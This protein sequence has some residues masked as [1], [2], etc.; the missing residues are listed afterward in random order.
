MSA[1]PKL[2]V[3]E[4]WGVGDQAM[5]T[6]FLQEASRRYRVWLLGKPYAA[7]LRPRFWPQV[8][9]IPWT[10][11][12]TV[13]RGKYRLHR[14]PWGEIARV[15]MRLRRERFDFGVSG[16]WDPRD[17]FLMFLAGVRHRIGFRRAGSQL[18]LTRALE[19]PDPRAHRYD[20][21]R[22]AGRPLEIDLPERSQRKAPPATGRALGVV[23]TG[24]AQPVRVWPLERYRA[25]VDRLRQRGWT[26]QV[27]C[28]SGQLNEW[29]QQ[30]EPAAV[31][32][33]SVSDLLDWMDRA[34]WFVGNDSGAG[35]LAAMAGVRTFTIFGPQVPAGFTPL[36][37]EAEYIEGK[38]CPAKPCFDL[39]QYAEPRCLLGVS[40]EEVWGRLEPWLGR[41]GQR[42]PP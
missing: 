33:G 37:P 31:A 27:L 35:H 13:L 29:R 5:A 42:P 38:P 18:W 19:P 16:R 10:A 40:F 34:A 25:L 3:V 22:A 6:P 1:A 11:P 2:L 9:V 4:L 28:D 20:L 32:P 41:P 15:G 12:W 17:H 21:W 30:G 39:C 24:A 26:V 23:H 14:W 8:E 7:D 36:H